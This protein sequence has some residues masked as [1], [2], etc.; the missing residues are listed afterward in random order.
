MMFLVLQAHK[1]FIK[2]F[3]DESNYLFTFIPTSDKNRSQPTEK[4][5]PMR[6]RI[7]KAIKHLGLKIAGGG[8]D[9]VFYFVDTKTDT[10]LVHAES[11][12]VSAMTHLTLQEWISEA[13]HAMKTE[14]QAELELLSY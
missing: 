2:F 9:G 5:K 4:T 14:L 7:N 6:K 13:E 10:C 11:V 3:L 1:K 12:Y 8:R